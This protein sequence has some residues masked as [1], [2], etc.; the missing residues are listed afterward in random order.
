MPDKDKVSLL[1]EDSWRNWLAQ[2][3]TQQ[4]FGAIAEKKRE[5]EERAG[6]GKWTNP[7]NSEATQFENGV[8]LGYLRAIRMIVED[9]L[10]PALAEE[11]PEWMKGLC[12]PK[13]YKPLKQDFFDAYDTRYA[14]Q[15]NPSL[16]GLGIHIDYKGRPS[17]SWRER[18]G[19]A[20]RWIRNDMFWTTHTCHLDSAAD[21]L[22]L[23]RTARVGLTRSTKP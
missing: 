14:M 4:F 7:T 20:W 22:D 16:V 10:P 23:I 6:E 21:I 5:M 18:I 11:M 2:P 13:A 3:E 8:G 17:C 12:A 19:M 1:D 15:V 9:I